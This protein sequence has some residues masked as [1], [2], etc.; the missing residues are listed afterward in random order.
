[1][2][3]FRVVEDKCPP[4]QGNTL[5]V[6]GL[7]A[8]ITKAWSNASPP[9]GTLD[10]PSGPANS[11]ALDSLI[12]SV[13]PG[14]TKST[15]GDIWG[16]V[17]PKLPY[18]TASTT[19]QTWA[20]PSSNAVAGE[21]ASTTAT[22]L[23]CQLFPSIKEKPSSSNEAPPPK[24]TTACTFQTSCWSSQTSTSPTPNCGRPSSFLG[25]H[26]APQ[27]DPHQG[28]VIKFSSLMTTS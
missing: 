1:M 6:P 11:P 21:A 16:C 20:D 13:V 4:S 3:C 10:K 25:L 28:P 2:S 17:T 8:C 5:V 22:T 23:F 19:L 14:D 15:N 24:S 26:R 18:N 7:N 9:S 27:T 12:V